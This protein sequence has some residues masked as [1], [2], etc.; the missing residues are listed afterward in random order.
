M[1][2]G[3]SIRQ[4]GVDILLMALVK[5]QIDF[6][7]LIRHHTLSRRLFVQSGIWRSLFDTVDTTMTRRY[8]KS[9]D[10]LEQ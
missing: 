8:F 2:R 10:Y 5:N 3:L 4:S 1:M 7:Q 6:R 9:L